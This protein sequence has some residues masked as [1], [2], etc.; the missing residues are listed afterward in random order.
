MRLL[1][2]NDEVISAK[3]LMMG[4]QWEN[5]GIL[6][7]DV[8]FEAET[9]KK[10]LMER[11]FDIILCDIEMPGENGLELVS[12]IRQQEMDMEVIFLTCHADFEFAQEAIRLQCR[13]YILIPATHE[14]IAESIQEV[15]QTIHIHR[16]EKKQQQYGKLW[17]AEKEE[18]HKMQKK[19]NSP[20]EIVQNIEDYME[21]YLNDP[22]LNL[23]RIASELYMNA[24]YLNR[25]FKRLKGESIGQCILKKRMQMAAD[26]LKKG[27]L[28]AT[29][30]AELVGYNTYTAF[31]AAFKNY[32]GT[33][34]IK[35]K[36]DN[37]Y[38]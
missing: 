4:V 30:I 8:A 26:M 32:H 33:S 31:S 13:N 20:E 18:E 19:A 24:D 36:E 35:Y 23:S 27:E 7:V 11:K 15:V 10:K 12:W 25:I 22:E 16:E 38:K 1:I 17:L 9:A 21:R 29:K 2:V 6:E 37:I 28:G 14:K 3:G 5:Y 34:P